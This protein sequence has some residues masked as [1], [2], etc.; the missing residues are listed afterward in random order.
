MS[1]NLASLPLPSNVL[2]FASAQLEHARVFD[3]SITTR[4]HPCLSGSIPYWMPRSRLY[5]FVD[6]GPGLSPN[7]YDLPVSRSSIFEIGEITA[8]VPHAPA[9]SNYASSSSGI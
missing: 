6:T 9:S 3:Y 5:N 4:V 2:S 8:A 7:T 1:A